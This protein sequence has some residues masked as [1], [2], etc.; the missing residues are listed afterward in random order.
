M[1]LVFVHFDKQT[2]P[3]GVPLDELLYVCQVLVLAEIAQ[4]VVLTV[5]LCV[6]QK[7]QL[8]D[9][10]DHHENEIVNAWELVLHDNLG[11]RYA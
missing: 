3:F 4:V 9:P 7:T 1:L 8:M 11:D 5:H 10:K 2:Q 6:V